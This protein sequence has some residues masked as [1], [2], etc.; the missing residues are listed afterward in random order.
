MFARFQCFSCKFVGFNVVFVFGACF[1]CLGCFPL[2]SKSSLFF[3]ESV[4]SVEFIDFHEKRCSLIPGVFDAFPLFRCI[5]L[6]SA[7]PVVFVRAMLLSLCCHCLSYYLLCPLRFP[8]CLVVPAPSPSGGALGCSRALPTPT[9]T[10][11]PVPR[12]T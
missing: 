6:C 11:T 12:L 5:W 8:L 2:I 3:G 4:F 1:L 9:P 7:F 10:V